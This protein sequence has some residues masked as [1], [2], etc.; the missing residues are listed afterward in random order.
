[1]HAWQPIRGRELVGYLPWTFELAPDDAEHAAAWKHLLSPAELGG[2]AGPRTVEP[3][4]PDYMRQYRYDRATGLRECQWNG[5]TWP[6]QT[7]QALTGM[8]NLLH[9]DHQDVVTRADYLR[10]LQQYAT[11]HVQA[12]KLDLQEDYDPDTGQPIVGLPR[13][14]HYNHSGYADLI[15]TGLVGLRPR[16]DDELE[17]DPLVPTG[18]NRPDLLRPAGRPLSRPSGHGRFRRDRRPLSSRS[19]PVRL[20]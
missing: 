18:L 15:I 16:A 4:Y 2:R 10:L 14:H 13:S 20:C 3:S 5:P 6:F 8:A 12:G 17:V 11:L 7:T 9:D 19:R 1:M